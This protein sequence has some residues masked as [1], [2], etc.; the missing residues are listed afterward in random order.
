[1]PKR[2][3]KKV[4][5]EQSSSP[6]SKMTKCV[7]DSVAYNIFFCN[8][9]F[10]FDLI[11]LSFTVYVSKCVLF[12]CLCVFDFGTWSI[13]LTNMFFSFYNSRLNFFFLVHLFGCRL[14]SCLSVKYIFFLFKLLR[15]SFSF[16]HTHTYKNIMHWKAL[17]LIN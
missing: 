17:N 11:L 10:F 7:Q 1:M 4:C 14:F 6:N 3:V 16:V 2:L 5:V 9:T 8:L 13:Y 15:P 12:V